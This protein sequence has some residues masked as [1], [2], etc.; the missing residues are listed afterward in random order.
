MIGKK[1]PDKDF[2]RLVFGKVSQARNEIRPDLIVQEDLSFFD[3]PPHH[4]M[5]NSWAI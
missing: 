3:S 2:H 4:V 5:Q 1:G